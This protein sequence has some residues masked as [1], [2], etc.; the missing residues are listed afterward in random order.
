[1]IFWKDYINNQFVDYQQL[2]NVINNIDSF[3]LY[4]KE[5][6]SFDFFVNLLVGIINDEHLVVLDAD[7]SSEEEERLLGFASYS[8]KRINLIKISSVDMLIEYCLKSTSNITIFT[9][10]TT[11]RPK[12]VKQ[13]VKNFLRSVKIGDKFSSNVWA[14]AYNPAHMAGLQVFF[15]GFLNLNVF[16]FVFGAPRTNIFRAIEENSITNISATPTFYRGLIPTEQVFKSVKKLTM[17]GEQF[18]DSIARALQ[19]NFPN[20]SWRNIYAST[21]AGALFISKGNAFIVP[22]DM[23]Q[24]IKIKDGSLYIHQTLLGIGDYD[25]IDNWYATG[26]LVETLETKPLTFKIIGRQSE[27]INVGGYKV[28]PHEVEES[29]MQFPGIKRAKVYGK[30]NLLLGNVV[31]AEIET[32]TEK[33]T[34]IELKSFL[35]KNLQ[36]F[37]I[38]SLIKQVESISVTKTGKL[39]RSS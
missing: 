16:N 29:L 34:E 37:K 4:I 28:N 9:S 15:Q 25:L 26:D 6:K 5:K 39:K 38:P 19:K 30:K 18:D 8:E 35:S 10:G 7:L 17:G 14:F 1:M 22:E 20:A 2:V 31:V 21:E 36:E 12:A 23:N 27:L 33:I 24:L 11:G 3:P 13:P 32:Y